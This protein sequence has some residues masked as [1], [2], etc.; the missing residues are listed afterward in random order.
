MIVEI[1]QFDLPPG[2]KRSEATELYQRSAGAWVKNKDLV[3]KYYFY[4][5]ATCRGGGVYVWRS[6]E[7]AQRWH[8]EE[9]RD[10]VRRMYG[11]P[12]RIEILILGDAVLH[13]DPAQGKIALP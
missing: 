5:E 12:P 1:V 2:T 8:G 6:R 4:D 10:M 3:Q 7:A 13:V 11:S 9:Y